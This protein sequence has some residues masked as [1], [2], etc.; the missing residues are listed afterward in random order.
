[1][2]AARTA[3]P[4]QPR[5]RGMVADMRPSHHRL[6]RLARPSEIGLQRRTYH[7]RQN[8]IGK[9]SGRTAKFAS[10][11]RNHFSLL[12]RVAQRTEA[13]SQAALE[14]SHDYSLDG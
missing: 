2:Q 12:S 6:S 4:I 3:V 1:M 9:A 10:A 7:T 11:I 13:L 14:E 5:S 8:R